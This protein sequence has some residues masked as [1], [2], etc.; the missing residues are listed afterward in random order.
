MRLYRVVIFIIFFSCNKFDSGKDAL[1]GAISEKPKTETVSYN[2]NSQKVRP[3]DITQTKWI[4]IEKTD[5][6]FKVLNNEWKRRVEVGENDI[7]IELQE[8]STYE[9]SHVEQKDN[10]FTFFIKGAD[11]RYRFRWEDRVKKICRWDYVNATKID[12][13]FSYYA[14][15]EKFENQL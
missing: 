9:L 10:E 11:W 6:K 5:S 2:E 8:P 4:E 13:S 14:V 1:E 15:L 12:S 7:V 3:F